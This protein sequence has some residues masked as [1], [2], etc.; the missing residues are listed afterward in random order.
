MTRPLPPRDAAVKD[1]HGTFLRTRTDLD[2]RDPDLSRPH[3]SGPDLPT[4]G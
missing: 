2:Q 3:V 4:K 1:Y